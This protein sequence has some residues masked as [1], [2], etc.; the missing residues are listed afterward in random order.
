[1]GYREGYRGRLREDVKDCGS[2]MFIGLMGNKHGIFGRNL[3][4]RGDMNPCCGII[5]SSELTIELSIR[6]CKMDIKLMWKI[7]TRQH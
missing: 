6:S 2:G 3:N 5:R 7:E 1:M 4:F